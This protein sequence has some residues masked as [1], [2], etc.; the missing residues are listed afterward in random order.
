MKL[1]NPIYIRHSNAI[2]SLLLSAPLFV[3]K[4]LNLLWWDNYSTTVPLQLTLNGK[5]LIHPLLF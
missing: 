5:F 4:P 1:E 3:L 2:L